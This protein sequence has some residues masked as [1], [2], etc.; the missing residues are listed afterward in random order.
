M[1]LNRLLWKMLDPFCVIKKSFHVEI[2]LK[3]HW[4]NIVRAVWELKTLHVIRPKLQNFDDFP[5]SPHF[6][7]L[8]KKSRNYLLV[9]N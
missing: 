7:L 5:F 6:S 2:K 9:P 8:Q 4:M 3:I 1:L